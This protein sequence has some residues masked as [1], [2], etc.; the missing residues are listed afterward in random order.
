MAFTIDLTNKGLFSGLY[1]TVWLNNGALDSE[2]EDIIQSGDATE[3]DT[4]D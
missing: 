1:E 3:S 2:V 4:L